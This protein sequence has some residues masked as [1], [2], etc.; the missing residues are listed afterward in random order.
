MKTT[1]LRCVVSGANEFF[2][3]HTNVVNQK[4]PLNFLSRASDL[5]GIVFGA[6]CPSCGRIAG[7]VCRDCLIRIEQASQQ[8]LI[9]YHDDVIVSYMYSAE[10][11]KIILAFKYRNMR[12]SLRFL[13]DAVADRIL[14]ERKRGLTKIDVV[15]WAP[16]TDKRKTARGHDHAELI[17]KYFARKIDVQCIKLLTRSSD[18]PQTG[19]SREE[20]LVGPIFAAHKLRSE[21]VLVFDDVI[22]TGATLN[23][24]T[25]ALYQAGAG[26]VSRV[27]IASTVLWQSS[28]GSCALAKAKK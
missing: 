12:S 22:T 10:I 19:K 16:T 20:R 6:T 7:Q 2:S 1:R 15:T 8:N 5:L 9:A 14:L 25:H 3:V 24:A 21:H 26:L 11:R 27:A 4:H 18:Q 28:T 13:G 23:S 17:A